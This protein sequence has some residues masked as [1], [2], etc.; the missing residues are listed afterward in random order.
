MSGTTIILLRSTDSGA[1]TLSGTAGSLVSLLDACLQDGYNS[2]TPSS[3]TRTGSTVTFTYS[4]AHGYAADGLTKV[5]ASGADQTEYN[6][7]FQI[8]NVSTLSF[9]VTVTGT[10]ATPATGTITTKAAP[11]G[12]SKTYS[13]TNKAVYRSN[14]STGTRLYLR[15]DD[16]NPS[17]DTGQ[18]ARVR[19]YEVMTDV[20]TGTGL[21]PTNA[22]L[23]GGL[24]IGKSDTSS[25]ASR[26]WILI[27]DGFEFHFF[28]VNNIASYN[29]IYRQFH[30]GDPAAEMAADP[31][32]CLIYGDYASALANPA[33]S[34]QTHQLGSNQSAQSGH[35]YARSYTQTGASIG[36]GKL[37]SGNLGSLNIGYGGLFSYPA[38]HNNGLY[39]A[40]IVILDT[41]V[42]RGQLKAI[43]QP[44]H[45]TPPLGNGILLAANVSPIG[46]RLFSIS[47]AYNAATAAETHLDID[48]PWR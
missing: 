31:Y 26:P 2:K 48:G 17:A 36:A 18:T 21:F 19:G 13:G 34:T 38:P 44:L 43:Y 7:L 9:D 5:L 39:I 40:P 22:Q 45:A 20:D 29:N 10:P 30:F 14:E 33:S 47:T 16:A 35:Y 27:G 37:G 1:P 32:G 46:R 11:L 24:W 12:W 8:S 15:V 4:S 42:L 3:V 28:Y 6:G 25:T 23:S 41:V